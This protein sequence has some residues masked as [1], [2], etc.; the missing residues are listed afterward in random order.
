MNQ[1]NIRV[2]LGAW[3]EMRSQA[4][5]IRFA[6]FVEEQKV[7]L[8]LELDEMDVLSLHALALDHHG[9]AVATGRLLPDGHIGRMAVKQSERKRGIGAQVLRA[10][11]EAAVFKGYSEVLLGAQLHATGFYARQ[12]FVEYGEIFMD[13]NIPHIMM[14]K[15]LA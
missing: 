13:A 7:P 3:D 10:L 15:K 5:A 4:S 1:E 2:V 6:V 14:K 9:E 12:G 8:A 11:T